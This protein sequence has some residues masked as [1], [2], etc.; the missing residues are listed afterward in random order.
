MPQLLLLYTRVKSGIYTVLPALED[1][2]PTN[3]IRDSPDRKI[4]HNFL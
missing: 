4:I 1:K 3:L 2:I